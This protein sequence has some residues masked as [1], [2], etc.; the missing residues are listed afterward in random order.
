MATK[1]WTEGRRRF[2]SRAGRANARKQAALGYP[3]LAKG[4]ATQMRKRAIAAL[5]RYQS[6][7]VVMVGVCSSCRA[8]TSIS[9][10]DLSSYST[11]AMRA[12][13][14]ELREQERVGKAKGG[15]PL[16]VT[17]TTPVDR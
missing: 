12:A 6:M 5:L 11:E 2:R 13:V 14:G 15:R 10:D 3:L 1:P 16:G 17:P 7:H 4:R 9:G 8:Y